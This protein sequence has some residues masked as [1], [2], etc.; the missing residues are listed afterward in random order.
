[1]VAAAAA[2]ASTIDASAVTTIRVN[3]DDNRGDIF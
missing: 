2:G 3:C 1:M